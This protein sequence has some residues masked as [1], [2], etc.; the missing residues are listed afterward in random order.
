MSPGPPALAPEI[1]DLRRQF[2][3]ISADADTLVT[4]LS[5][6][7]FRWRPTPAVWSIAHC[8]DHLNATAR[9]YLPSLDEGISDAIRRGLYGTGP[10]RYD[11]MGRLF[12]WLNEPPPRVKVKAPAVFQPPPN[13]TRH[14]VMAAFRAYQVQFVDRLRQ[15]NGVDLARARVKSPVSAWLRISLGSGL[16]VMAAHERRHI[17]QARRLMDMPGFPAR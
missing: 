13:R 14:E 2:E 15:A 8:L 1:D 6:D 10:Y 17:W 16:H 12:T 4:P 3:L 5:D 11:W 9:T 7:Q